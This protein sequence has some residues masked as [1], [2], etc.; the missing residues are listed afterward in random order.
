MILAV[1]G[2][3]GGVVAF[4][5]A[6]W[7][8]VRAIFRQSGATKD[9]TEAVDRLTSSVDKMNGEFHHLSERVSRLEGALENRNR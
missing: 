9:N 6:V 3:L 5:G 8:V 4:V 1:L 2:S 7:V